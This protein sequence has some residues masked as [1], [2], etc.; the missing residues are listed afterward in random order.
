MGLIQTQVHY[1][2][3]FIDCWRKGKSEGRLDMPPSPEGGG[4]HNASRAVL[5][6]LSLTA[7][8]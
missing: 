2:Q 3:N 7:T 6:D 5:G 4:V 8:R 1:K